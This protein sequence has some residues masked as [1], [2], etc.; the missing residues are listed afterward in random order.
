MQ[1]DAVTSASEPNSFVALFPVPWDLDGAGLLAEVHGQTWIEEVSY[2]L[3]S[4]GQ[5]R[6]A[7]GNGMQARIDVDEPI[8]FLAELPGTVQDVFTDTE[9]VLLREHR[10]IWRVSMDCPKAEGRRRAL[11]F[12]QIISTFVEAGACGVFMP[13]T[14]Q[15]HAPGF[16]KLQAME[17]RNIPSLVNLF[18]TAWDNG[19]WMGTRGLTAFGL[20]ELET[21]INEGLNAAYY[22]LMDVASEMLVLQDSFAP[23][24]RLQLGPKYYVVEPGPRGMHDEETPVC[25]AF[26]RQSIMPG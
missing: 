7:F 10:A 15:L 9:R 25:G 22:R 21:P 13:M 2:T 1:D 14:R 12:G 18:V 20:P 5:G 8:P 16:V 23:D 3:D 24:T 26:G 17:L 11:R 6:I 19:S 4:D